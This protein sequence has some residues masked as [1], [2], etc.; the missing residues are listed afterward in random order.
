MTDQ[1]HHPTVRN[2]SAWPRD[3]ARWFAALL[4]FAGILLVFEPTGLHILGALGCLV[5]AGLALFLG[6]KQVKSLRHEYRYEHD[7]NPPPEDG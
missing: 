5:G 6:K 3:Q 2:G 1:R 4:V 7:D